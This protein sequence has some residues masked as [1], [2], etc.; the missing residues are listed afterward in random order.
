MNDAAGYPVARHAD[1][2]AAR[3]SRARYLTALRFMLSEHVRN[4]TAMILLL[5]FVPI[6]YGLIVAIFGHQ[7][8]SFRFRA[9]GQFLAVDGQE[10]SVI[11][12][13]LNSLTLIVGFLIFS[14]TKRGMTFTRRLVLCGY[15]RWILLG[16]QVTAFI[17]ASLA[18]S[19]YGVL[20]LLAFW[21][22]QTQITVLALGFFI[23]SLAYAALGML[24][25]VLVRGELEGFFVVIMLSLIDTEMQNPIGNPVGNQGFLA[26]FPSFGATQ[27]AVG[28]GFTH[29][30][31]WASLGVGLAWPAGFT[32]L[33]ALVFAWRTRV[34]RSVRSSGD[35][36]TSHDDAVSAR[37]RCA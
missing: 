24:L 29:M 20:I 34:P 8:A 12:A 16:A 9:T 36:S 31:P 2:H 13:G 25:G 21:R 30:I 5:A 15:P 35:P 17:A 6:W 19:L 22:S 14:G 27:V 11:S 37:P 18:I 28:G 33:A 10:L 3:R 32:L 4:R 1:A 7:L 26:F 23:G